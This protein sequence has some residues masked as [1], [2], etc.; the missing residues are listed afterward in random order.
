MHLQNPGSSVVSASDEVTGA[1]IVMPGTDM[2]SIHI[3]ERRRAELREK[4]GT[5]A[6]K[7]EAIL[8]LRRGRIV[9]KYF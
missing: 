3:T 8:T 6:N 2:G 7:A 1:T 5:A 9:V 4:F